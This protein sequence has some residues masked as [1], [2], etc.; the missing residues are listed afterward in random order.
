VKEGHLK[1]PRIQEAFRAIDRADFILPESQSNAYRNYPL[2]IGHNQTISQPLTVALLLE[3]LAP[4]PGENIL[5]IG[6]GSGWTTALLAHTV[7][8][9]GR[10]VGIERIPDLCSFGKKNISKYFD[11]SR[12]RIA[13]VDGFPG[14][15]EGAPFNKILAG[16]A[17]DA[18]IPG[19][20]RRQL[21]VGGKIVAPIGNSVWVFT[22]RS[23][24]TWD[25]KEIPG[26]SFVPLVHDKTIGSQNKGSTKAVVSESLKNKR[27]Y[28]ALVFAFLA[29]GFL[30]NEIYLPF[31]FQEEKTIVIPSGLGSRRIGELLKNSG[32]IR[33]KWLFV[34]YVSLRGDASRLKPGRYTWQ[35]TSLH[36]VA[37]DLARGGANEFTMV[38]PEGWRAEDIALY[39]DRN[40]IITS[41]DFL[42]YI[43]TEHAIFKEF[44]FLNDKPAGVGL[45]GYLFPDTYRVFTHSESSDIVE[46]M[47]TNFD[48]KLTVDLR[49]EIVRQGKTI[50]EIITMASLIEKEVVSDDDRALVSG[51]LWK[52]LEAGIP[53]QV[54]AT[55][56]YIRGLRSSRVSLEDTLVDSP[57]NTYKYLGLPSGPIAN[58]GLSAIRAA[59][60][61]QKSP[62]LYYLSTPDGETIFS[63]TLE[64]HNIAKAKYLTP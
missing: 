28:V 53:L 44:N 51:V 36:S 62:H 57:Y 31:R 59:L 17:A 8:A 14:F 33:S 23:E 63:R 18:D 5:D 37:G 24:T 64:E 3:L 40:K 11:E 41:S 9:G 20:W 47:L 4:E 10:V 16:A 45:E 60:D 50:F 12:A 48:K 1:T 30:I 56:V 21:K 52:R 54:D 42:E 29:I 32:V 2:S 55:I 27:A 38:V 49:N 35:S 39:L 25:E 22:K 34:T 15:E 61:P 19:A 13:C 26:F 7:G 58:P 43:S 46:K 6:S